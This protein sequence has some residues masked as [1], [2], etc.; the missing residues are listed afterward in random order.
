M[1]CQRILK[2]RSMQLNEVNINTRNMGEGMQVPVGGLNTEAM[3]TKPPDYLQVSNSQ[4]Y[5]TEIFN[6]SNRKVS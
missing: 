6:V 2:Q 3:F 4:L 1:I 5:L